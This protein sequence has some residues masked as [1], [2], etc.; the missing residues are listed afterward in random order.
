[1]SGGARAYF[2]RS[3]RGNVADRPV[4]PKPS[5]RGIVLSAMPARD[6]YHEHVRHA[7]EDAVGQFVLY[8]HALRREEP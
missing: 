6:T 1:M 4:A 8:E 7:L 2:E 3:P 5:A